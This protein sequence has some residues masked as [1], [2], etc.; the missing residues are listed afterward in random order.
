MSEQPQ[1]QQQLEHETKS[2]PKLDHNYP[3]HP[4]VYNQLVD[5]MSHVFSKSKESTDVEKQ[6]EIYQCQVISLDLL[7]KFTIQVLGFI[8]KIKDIIHVLHQA[9]GIKT[10][11]SVMK[12]KLAIQ[13]KYIWLGDLKYKEYDSAAIW[14]I[15]LTSYISQQ[16]T[17]A[18]YS[19]YFSN[20][21][22]QNDRKMDSIRDII[23]LLKD[24]ND[25]RK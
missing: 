7:Q 1:Q 2:V 20:L 15:M 22:S 14:R 9:F 4:F 16:G 17:R 23:N 13:T 8:P 11:G 19:N 12:L 6:R 3:I 5:T 25:A 21:V 18:Q 24:Q 10:F